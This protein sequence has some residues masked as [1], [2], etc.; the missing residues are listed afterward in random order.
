MNNKRIRV[1][2]EFC[3][4]YGNPESTTSAEGEILTP[5]AL[6]SMLTSLLINAREYLNSEWSFNQWLQNFNQTRH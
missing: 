1:K 6:N 5:K 3:D 4:M 2:I